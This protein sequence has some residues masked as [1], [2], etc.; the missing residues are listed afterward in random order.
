MNFNTSSLI[1]SINNKMFSLTYRQVILMGF[2][3][4]YIVNNYQFLRTIINKNEQ[5]IEDFYN[6]L[7]SLIPFPT[8]LS[9]FNL[10]FQ[11]N[12]RDFEGVCMRR[13]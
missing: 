2:R 13:V 12:M 7:S 8:F 3:P 4:K 1:G 6:S 5:L 9:V 11:L 10:V